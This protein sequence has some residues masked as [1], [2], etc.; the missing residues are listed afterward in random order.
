MR[1]ARWRCEYFAALNAK[2]D[3]LLAELNAV[4]GTDLA[5][6]N[7]AVHNEGIPPVS[8]NPKATR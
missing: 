7:A 2:L 6:F 3:V 1:R 5:G 8:V 4:L